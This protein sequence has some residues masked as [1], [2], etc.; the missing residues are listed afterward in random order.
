MRRLIHTPE[1]V[2]DIYGQ[3]CDKK[4]YLQRQ[5]EKLLRSYGYQS[6]ETPSFEFFEVFGKEV[7]TIASRNLYKFF[8]RDGNTL[9]LRPDF[10][11][12]VARAASMYFAEEPMPIRLCYAGSVFINNSSY[13][14]RLKEST[15]M[16]VELL[17]DDSP[18]ADAELVALVVSIM[19][20]AGLQEFQ[21]SIGAA[22]FFRSLVEE[23]QM[24]EE[25]VAQLRK[26]LTIKN[27]FG[28][29]ELIEKLQL[30]S[31]LEEA[32]RQIPELFGTVDVLAKARELTS[33]EKALL[34][35]ERLEKI[36]EILTFY[37][38]QS[39]VSF[40][41]SLLSNYEY[42]T[43]ILFQAYTYGSGDAV[44]KGGRYDKLLGKFGKQ[45]PAVGFAVETDALLSAIE[46]QKLPLPLED[47]KIMLLYPEKLEQAAIRWACQWREQNHDVA[48]LRMEADR[49]L[50]DYVSYGRRNQFRTIVQ[51]QS[52]TQ[53]LVCHLADGSRETL[54]LE[55]EPGR[56]GEHRGHQQSD[57]V[58]T[59]GKKGAAAC[60]I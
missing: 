23:A 8:D 21:I 52:Q 18:Q 9:V 14:G 39:Y 15:Q 25:T 7:G 11:P 58:E 20:R 19:K 5:I 24:Q 31:H 2:R 29:Q 26:L 12:S 34:A 46:R 48:C 59:E 30:P 1:G 27:R 54:N 33:N 55:E 49:S 4:R 32:F 28:A 36:Y 41:L 53:A 47:I 3:E 38:C 13:Q 6:I 40:D 50:E 22:D 37:G 17:N 60:D 45:S 57:A 43:G 10:T 42:Y 44:I 35:I 16:G 56:S 51:L